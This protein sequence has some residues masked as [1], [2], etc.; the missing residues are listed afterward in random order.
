MSSRGTW[1]GVLD[2]IEDDTG[3]LLDPEEPHDRSNGS[4]QGQERPVGARKAEDV[5]VPH[6]FRSVALDFLL[7][8]L[9]RLPAVGC[10]RSRL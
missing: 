2:F 6:S 5:M 1:A 8:W 10:W 9:G 4:Q 3:R 7:L